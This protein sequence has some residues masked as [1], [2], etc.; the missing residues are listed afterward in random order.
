M[1]NV[2]LM[3]WFWLDCVMASSKIKS[4]YYKRIIL[5]FTA[6]AKYLKIIFDICKPTQKN[7]VYC[8]LKKIYGFTLLYIGS[9]ADY[10]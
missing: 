8:S 3:L 2:I 5:C 4:F 6:L 10:F 7:R 9:E 1:E